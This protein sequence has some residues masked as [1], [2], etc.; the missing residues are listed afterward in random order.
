VI[1]H[2]A[3]LGTFRAS[4]ATVALPPGGTVAEPTRT[5]A[6]SEPTANWLPR[7]RAIADAATTSAAS[8]RPNRRLRCRLLVISNLLD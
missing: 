3:A 6:L 7:R 4:S 8:A 5:V 2:K 1:A